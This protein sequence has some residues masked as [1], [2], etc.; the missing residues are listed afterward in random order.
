MGSVPLQDGPSSA[1][2]A[3]YST[4]TSARGGASDWHALLAL[5]DEAELRSVAAVGQ[6]QNPANLLEGVVWAV[7]DPPEAA[8]LEAPAAGCSR[9]APEDKR[10]AVPACGPWTMWPG[11]DALY[12]VTAVT[13]ASMCR[14]ESEIV[15]DSEDED[16]ACVEQQQQQQLSNA[17]DCDAQQG[18][19]RCSRHS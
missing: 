9:R 17:A 7:T 1:A 5:L 3:A 6:Q 13:W 18:G 8:R 12:T 16:V 19:S 4:C 15:P 10:A 11:F 14:E 2:E